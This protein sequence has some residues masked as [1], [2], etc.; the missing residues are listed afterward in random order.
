MYLKQRKVKADT[1]FLKQLQL[2]TEFGYTLIRS[3]EP[4]VYSALAIPKINKAVK[5]VIE[6][7]CTL[8]SVRKNFNL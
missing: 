3:K 1:F 8:Y 4:S 7:Y 5:R 2:A 6:Y